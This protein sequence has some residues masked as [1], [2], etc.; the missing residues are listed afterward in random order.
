MKSMICASYLFPSLKTWG[1]GL[2]V[3]NLHTDFAKLIINNFL[4]IS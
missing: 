4:I 3:L 2:E 1:T